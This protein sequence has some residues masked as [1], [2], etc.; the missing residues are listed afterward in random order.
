[1]LGVGT[2]ETKRIWAQI[3]SE[4][5]QS[6]KRIINAASEIYQIP[7]LT[8]ARVEWSIGY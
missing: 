8:E 1:M 3:R 7:R 4:G 6:A 5:A 2:E